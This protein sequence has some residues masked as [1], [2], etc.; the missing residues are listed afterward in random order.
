[1]TLAG[2]A[3]VAA[4]GGQKHAAVAPPVRPQ[5]WRAVVTDLLNHGQITG[6]HRCGAV[7]EAVAHVAVLEHLPTDHPTL[8]YR[9]M[10]FA[11]D[12][13]ASQVCPKT[14]QLT[15]VVVGMSDA[16]VADVAGMPRTPRLRC[17]L[18]P[19]TRASEGR[20]VC[21]VHGHVALVQRSVHG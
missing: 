8:A 3:V 10:I 18:Y 4:C 21:F 20:R 19:V 7:V 15:K 9:R 6:R 5:E 13:Y 2:C 1:L 14:P 12:R 17:W 16:D 11:L